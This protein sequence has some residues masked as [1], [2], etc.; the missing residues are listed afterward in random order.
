[1][2]VLPHPCCSVF[3][4]LPSRN[5]SQNGERN[6]ITWKVYRLTSG[7]QQTLSKLLFH[8]FLQ[9]LY[10]GQNEMYIQTSLHINCQRDILL[11]ICIQ[12]QYVAM[13][14]VGNKTTSISSVEE[15]IMSQ[16]WLQLLLEDHHMQLLQVMTSQKY[17]YL[18]LMESAENWPLCIVAI[19]CHSHRYRK[20][21]SKMTH[22]YKVQG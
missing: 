14:Y 17:S 1:M 16:S 18:I 15:L 2:N 9:V 22:Y 12:I 5:T 4:Y 7:G 8:E 3:W 20:F 21:A 6:N 11:Q 10:Y 19:P 13:T